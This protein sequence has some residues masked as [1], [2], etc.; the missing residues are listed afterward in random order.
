MMFQPNKWMHTHRRPAFQVGRSGFFEGWIC[1]QRT[2]PAVGDPCRWAAMRA[3]RAKL[4]SCKDDEIIAQGKRRAAP[5]P[6]S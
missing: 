4:K 1:S 6:F 5:L 3:E 2:F